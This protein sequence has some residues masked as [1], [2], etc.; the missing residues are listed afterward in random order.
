LNQNIK[1]ETKGNI[2]IFSLK[3][4]LIIFVTA[5]AINGQ[6]KKLAKVFSGK[7]IVKPFTY[8]GRVNSTKMNHYF[9]DLANDLVANVPIP[10]DIKCRNNLGFFAF[11]V[12]RYG[13]IAEL[14]YYG[15][16]DSSIVKVIN[17]NIHKTD[18]KFSKPSKFSQAQFHWFVLPF[19]SNGSLLEFRSCPNAG[20]LEIEFDFEF[21]H[22]LS[23]RKLQLLFPKSPTVTILP[24]KD[25]HTEMNKKDL[26]KGAVM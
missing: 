2:V 24:D 11:K 15:D 13:K 1:M 17:T 10:D 3:T 18:G 22:Y 25:H 21:K 5:A 16:L 9:D 20:Q 14:E 6:N 12:D 23:F 8:L 7:D 19:L 4:I 26:I